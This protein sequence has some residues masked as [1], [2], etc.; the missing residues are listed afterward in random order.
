[1]E[2]L[3]G[4]QNYLQSSMTG[5]TFILSDEELEKARQKTI[6]PDVNSGL[7][8]GETLMY[9]SPSSYCKKENTDVI[10]SMC[11]IIVKNKDGVLKARTTPVRALVRTQNIEVG[12]SGYG[13]ELFVGQMTDELIAEAFA[14][15]CPMLVEEV[16]L[17]PH[18]FIEGRKQKEL[19]FK[20]LE[21][22]TAKEKKEIENFTF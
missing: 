22:L 3:T 17:F 19:T 6:S 11:A 16:T 21:A 2:T 14:K 9:V 15:G 18:P 1:M 10:F 8:K 4:H 7:F 12:L 5:F 20:K 13:R